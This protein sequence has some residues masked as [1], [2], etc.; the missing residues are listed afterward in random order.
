MTS[1]MQNDAGRKSEPAPGR[2][3]TRLGVLLVGA[4]LALLA[5]GTIGELFEVQWILNLPWFLPP[6]KF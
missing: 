1:Q 4:Y 2:R 3:R 6:G 5:L